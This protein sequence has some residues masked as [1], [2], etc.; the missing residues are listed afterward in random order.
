MNIRHRKVSMLLNCTAIEEQIDGSETSAIEN[1]VCSDKDGDAII[2]LTRDY[3][4]P[5]QAVTVRW[6]VKH[7]AERPR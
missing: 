3:L 7:A 5:G 4:Q 6:E 1:L 2:T